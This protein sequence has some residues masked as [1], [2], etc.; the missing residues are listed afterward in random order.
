MNLILVQCQNI[1]EIAVVY[2][3]GGVRKLPPGLP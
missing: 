1:A 2:A 3:S